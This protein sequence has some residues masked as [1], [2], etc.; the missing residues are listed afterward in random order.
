MSSCCISTSHL[1]ILRSQ[2][3]CAASGS[4]ALLAPAPKL[5]SLD[6][7]ARQAVADQQRL[8]AEKAALI[9]T[10]SASPRLMLSCSPAR[11]HQSVLH[12]SRHT[13]SFILC[14]NTWMPCN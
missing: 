4:N 3:M 7:Q 5:W 11:V 12:T 13:S 8:A 10:V 9:E 2:V 6:E 1:C 14:H